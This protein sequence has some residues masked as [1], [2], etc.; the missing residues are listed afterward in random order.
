LTRLVD[1]A[2]PDSLETRRLARAI[3][4]LLDDA[5]AFE[6]GRAELAATFARWRDT[7]PVLDRLIDRRPILHEAR[8]LAAGLASLAEAGRSALDLLAAGV[9]PAAGWRDDVVATLDAA[10][11]PVAEVELPVVPALRR[12]V[13]GAAMVGEVGKW[14]PQEWKKKVVEAA[15]PPPPPSRR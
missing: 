14:S 1:A 13:F 5:P 8:P 6:R 10:A 12:L 3:D 7:V 15:T 2:Q 11:V 4:R 9:Q